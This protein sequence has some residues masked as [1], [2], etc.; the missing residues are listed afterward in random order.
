MPSWFTVRRQGDSAHV[1]IHGEICGYTHPAEA[2]LAELD[3]ATKADVFIDSPGGSTPDALKIYER[4]LVVETRVLIRS[5]RSAAAL[6]AQ[7][8]RTRKIFQDGHMMIHS[9]IDFVSGPATTLRRRADALDSVN[10]RLKNILCKH[11]GQRRGVVN[12]WL[13]GDDHWFTADEAVRAGL[14]DE[15]IKSPKR[16]EQ[17]ADGEADGQITE[18]T[19]E[20]QLFHSLLR[21]FPN[22]RVRS[23]EQFRRELAV[24]FSTVRD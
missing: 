20:E 7:A 16:V 23:R 9:P 24:F 6:I 1:S 14:A 17:S 2:L 12:G 13:T 3:G 10:H 22:L 15:I 11:T 4:L 18:A 8:G 5:A 21:G 19:V